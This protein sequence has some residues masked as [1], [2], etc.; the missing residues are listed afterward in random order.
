M[1]VLRKELDSIYRAQD[2]A[3][4]SLDTN[5]IADC[6]AM[7]DTSV[8]VSDDCCVITDA[9]ADTCWIYGGAF[10]TM[11][12]LDNNAGL[13]MPCELK[14]SDED[15]IYNRVHPEDLVDKRMLE[16]EFLKFTD[17]LNGNEKLRYK[18]TCSIRVRNNAGQYI[19][20][21]NSTKIMRLSPNGRI[22]L[23]LCRYDFATCKKPGT[24]ISPVI[25]NITTGCI[26]DIQLTEK[27]NRIL[28]DREK[29]ILN[30]IKTGKPSKQIA[31]ILGI[32]IH[33]VNRHRQNIIEKL[34]VSNTLEAVVAATEMRLL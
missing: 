29:D 31:D 14:S 4:E 3:S 15:I 11:I 13:M 1:D 8:K 9:S 16:Y 28:T 7:V 22:W 26:Q 6:Q 33:T 25:V 32:S 21:D 27:R 20:V 24:G 18:A 17:K 34:S 23:I 30:L 5:V 2:L 12:G 19:L 10:A